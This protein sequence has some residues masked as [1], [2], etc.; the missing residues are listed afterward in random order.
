LTRRFAVATALVLALAP[1]TFAGG[2]WHKTV[3]AAQKVAKEKNQLILVDMFA[4]WCGWCHRFEREV[5]PSEAFQ[6]ATDD[7][8]LLRLDTEDQKE[9]TEFQRKYQVTSLP[10][11]L[12]L[13]PDLT[14]AGSIRGYAPPAQFAQMLAE[15]RSKHAVFE[16][17]LKNEPNMTT[18]YPG[19]LEL[20]KEF[21]TRGATPQAETRFKKLTTEKGVPGSIRDEAFYQ[22]AFMYAT[23][24]RFDDAQKAI[25]GLTAV[26]NRGDAVERSKLLA[27][28]IY[29][30]QGNL[31]AAANELRA[32]K[33]AY[34]NSAHL[35][36]VDAVL[37]DIERRLN[38]NSK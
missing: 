23:Q 20:A 17:R 21:V 30:A 4:Q 10:T 6:K 37:P 18:D 1:Q 33:K 28:Q 8:V 32:F 22:L 13:T 16:K 38:G 9:G 5:F 24:N 25:K 15:T 31:L 14:L 2:S 35:P 11:F 19:R 26:S 7:I 36:T 29:V 27:G 12:L 3:A 34:P